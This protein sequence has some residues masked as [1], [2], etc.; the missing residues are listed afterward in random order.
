M[1]GETRAGVYNT[2]N[3]V[4]GINPALFTP[5][6]TVMTAVNFLDTNGDYLDNTITTLAVGEG[7]LVFPQA[8][9]DVGAVNYAHTYT[10]GTLNSGIVN[11]S[12]TYN[13]PATA[14]NFNLAGNPYPSAIDTDALIT[15]NVAIDQV[16]FWE[17]ITE[18]NENLPGFNTQNFSMDDVSLRNL[19][20]GTASVNGGTAPGQFMA[21]GQGFGILASQSEAAMGTD[22]V[23][24]N[25][26][27]LSG[28][29][30]T[31]RSPEQTNRLGLVLE[32]DGYTIGAHTLIGFIPEASPAIDPGYDSERLNTVISLFSTLESGEQLGIQGREV[33]DPEMEIALGF[34]TQI[35][36][37]ILYTISI[38][39]LEGLAL[40]QQGVFL[41]DHQ[42]EMITNLREG[43]YSFASSETIQ[44][45]RFSLVFEERAL[46]LDDPVIEQ[47]I[48]LYPNPVTDMLHIQAT[49]TLNGVEIYD[50][51][52]KKVR[53][54]TLNG[55]ANQLDVSTIR[56]GVYILYIQTDTGITTRRLI[57]N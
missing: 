8:V 51:L 41:I 35:Q 46:T 56:D 33:F 26:M 36:E 32:A 57:K 48:K 45:G 27:R 7:Y 52:G 28:N 43:A 18:P 49:T 10:Q 55:T 29:N 54:Y 23:F 14:N 4:F 15:A 24:N 50:M 13:G 39:V 38:D 16:Y 44:A 25:G 17:H 6:P 11:K 30:G 34:A 37:D 1:S 42:L 9:T 19:M 40:E 2:A 21:S 3:R 31:L 53:Q 47:Y 20:G 12:L 5:D 22:L